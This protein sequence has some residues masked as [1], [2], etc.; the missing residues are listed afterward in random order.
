MKKKK[1]KL[2]KRASKKNKTLKASRKS[3]SQSIMVL[4]LQITL[5]PVMK[6]CSVTLH[7]SQSE[8]IKRKGYGDGKPYIPFLSS[9]SSYSGIL[10][11]MKNIKD[12]TCYKV[13]V[14]LNYLHE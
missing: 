4:L 9:G 6:D 8:T 14:T 13:N 11:E 3:R 12:K 5:S 7:M 1:N 10:T 2:L